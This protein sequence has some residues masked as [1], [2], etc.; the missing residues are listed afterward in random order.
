MTKR[1]K[2]RQEQRAAEATKENFTKS[3]KQKVDKPFKVESRSIRSETNGV[4][5]NFINEA[6]SF[7]YE[8][9]GYKKFATQEEADKYIEK[10]LRSEYHFMKGKTE[11]RVTDTRKIE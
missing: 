2:T 8:W 3:R 11:Y 7:L 6:L 10:K 4:V 5:E 9:R 1:K